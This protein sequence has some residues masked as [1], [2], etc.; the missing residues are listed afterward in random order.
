MSELASMVTD[1]FRERVPHEFVVAA[2]DHSSADDVHLSPAQLRLWAELHELGL[3]GIGIAEDLGGSGG[4]LDDSVTLAFLAG[5]FAL[6]LP[7]V[8]H[9]LAVWAWAETGGQAPGEEQ[10]HAAWSI[11]LGTPNDTLEW[12]EGHVTGTLHDVPWGASAGRVLAPI[13]VDDAPAYVLLNPSL[14]QVEVGHDVA[15]EP[16]DRLTFS[17]APAQLVRPSEGGS[18][19]SQTLV[20]RAMLLRAAQ[21]AG[22]LQS[23]FE[24]T[25]KYAS[26]R[27]QFGRP[28]GAFQAVAA[29]VVQLAE[30][31]VMTEVA[32]RRATQEFTA[33]PSASFA[34]NAAK[35][36]ANQHAVESVR[37]GHQAHGA[38][39]MTREYALQ[40]FT[41][42]LNAWRGEWGSELELASRIGQAAFAHGRI[43]VAVTDEGSLSL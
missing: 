18:H 10:Q 42:R 34:I 41:R 29:H 15:G 17:Q 43:A 32:V 26:V 4:E 7:L 20:L 28:I 6:P 38:I 1:L 24:L 27:Q 22:A 35:L 19:D 5:K 23:V 40:D 21:M 39:G 9:Q 13:L 3:T 14:A 30:V 16:R 25:K 12:H 8:E 37:R 2:E 11:T 33:G 31:A 36:L